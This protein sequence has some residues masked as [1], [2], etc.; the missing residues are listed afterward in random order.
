MSEL[1]DKLESLKKKERKIPILIQL[2]PALND[3]ITKW[4]KKQNLAKQVAIE[5]LINFGFT[6]WQEAKEKDTAKA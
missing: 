2:P 5:Q 1:L 6:H 4:S 3:K